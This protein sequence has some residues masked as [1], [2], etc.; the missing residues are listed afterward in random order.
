MLFPSIISIGVEVV[1]RTADFIAGIAASKALPSTEFGY[2]RATDSMR[3]DFESVAPDEE[4]SLLLSVST[5][6]PEAPLWRLVPF[7]R[8]IE[9]PKPIRMWLL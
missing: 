8:L 2:T 1:G 5:T 9:N 6:L 4:Y 3:C 7:W